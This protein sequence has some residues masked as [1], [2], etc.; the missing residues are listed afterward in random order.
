MDLI[1][2]GDQMDHSQRNTQI[3]IGLSDL[4]VTLTMDDGGDSCRRF[5][6]PQIL[7]LL[8]TSVSTLRL[9]S[10][11]L[12]LYYVI[13]NKNGY[14]TYTSRIHSQYFQRPALNPS[15]YRCPP[16][17]TKISPSVMLRERSISS[18]SASTTISASPR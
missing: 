17:V 3:V 4:R 15:T 11:C 14:S 7:E 10:M 1:N 8:P 13:P 6:C 2:P 12:L 9:Q 18:S 5:E 16:P